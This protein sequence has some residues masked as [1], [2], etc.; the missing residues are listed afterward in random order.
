[1]RSEFRL[2]QTGA[3]WD[4]LSDLGSYLDWGRDVIK[5]FEQKRDMS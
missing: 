3:D 1:M 2:G 4:Q 5:G